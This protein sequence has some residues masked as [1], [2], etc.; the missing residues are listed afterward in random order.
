MKFTRDKNKIIIEMEQGD[1][2]NTED[3]EIAADAMMAGMI[4]MSKLSVEKKRAASSMLTE[5]AKDELASA[6]DDVKER[7]EIMS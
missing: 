2:L 3:L 7:W 1:I 5:I 6:L 4:V